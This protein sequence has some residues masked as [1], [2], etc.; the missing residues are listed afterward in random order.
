MQAYYEIE[1]EIPTSHRLDIQL[2]TVAS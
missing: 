2:L 1:T